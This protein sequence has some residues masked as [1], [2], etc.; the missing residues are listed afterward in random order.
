[1][2]EYVISKLKIGWSPEQIQLRLP[3]EY[4]TDNRMRISYEAIYI[5]IYD[6]IHRNGNGSVKKDCEDLRIYLSRRHTRRQ[7]KG[8]RKARKV[9]REEYLPSI[10][11]RPKEVEKRTVLGHWED[12]TLVSRQNSVRIKSVNERVSGIVFF[13]KTEDG[14]MK[15]CDK[16]VLRRLATIPSKFRKTLTRDRGTEN[17]NYREIEEKLSLSCYF[18]HSYCSHERGSNENVNGLLRRFFPKKTDFS[19]ITDE[20]LQEVEYR[21][22]SRPRKRLGG[23]TPYEVFY[24]ET[25]VALD[26]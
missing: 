10:E 16:V 8:F 25:G 26:S 9:E 17:M 12:D 7:K 23:F 24:R 22:N 18:A 5:Y 15:E 13:G 6:Q 14:T 20:E 11:K 2:R 19:K 21:I 3:L 1:M 4:P